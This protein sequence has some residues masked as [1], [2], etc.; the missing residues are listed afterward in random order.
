[1]TD[2][3]EGDTGPVLMLRPEARGGF[4]IEVD[5]HRVMVDPVELLEAPGN[6]LIR[7][8]LE[9]L[10]WFLLYK[11]RIYGNAA[12]DPLQVFSRVDVLDRINTRIDD[13]LQRIQRGQGQEFEDVERDLVGYFIIKRVARRLA[14]VPRSLFCLNEEQYEQLRVVRDRLVQDQQHDSAGAL[15]RI[16]SAPVEP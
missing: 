3:Y 16:L 5:G 2:A 13:K 4:H 9:A 12:L 1:M 7:S 14:G 15:S 10:L 8:E 6:R 11:N